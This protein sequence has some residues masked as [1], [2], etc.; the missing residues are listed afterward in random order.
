MAATGSKQLQKKKVAR[1]LGSTEGSRLLISCSG[2]D[3]VPADRQLVADIV[4]KYHQA[5]A[6]CFAA[7]DNDKALRKAHAFLKPLYA[8]RA[9]RSEIQLLEVPPA[10]SG[11][12]TFHAWIGPGI[13]G[14]KLRDFDKSQ[15]TAEG[16]DKWPLGW[17]NE[18]GVVCYER[19]AGRIR[20][21]RPGS[22][23]VPDG[24]F[25]KG[26]VKTKELA[27]AV[28]NPADHYVVIEPGGAMRYMRTSEVARAFMIPVN[29]A[30]T[31]VL[32]GQRLAEKGAKAL[33]AVQAVSCLGRCIHT[34]VARRIVHM[35][36]SRGALPAEPTYG[37]A[38]SGIDTFAAAVE[39]E[40]DGKFE[41]VFASEKER[42][43][44]D[45]LRCAWGRYG[46]TA[47]T[48]FRDACGADA[49]T[50]P[51]VDLW[52]CSPTCESY[53]K[54]N[55]DRQVEVQNLSLGKVW[56]SLQYVVNMRPRVVVMEN[57][58]EVGATGPMS[59][60]ISRL[61]GYAIYGGMLDPRSTAHA[62]IA[63]ER[64][65]WVMLRRD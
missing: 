12:A 32:L 49:T 62:P 9:A 34:G 64:Y 42:R 48:C 7:G 61:E 58:A 56:K 29:S 31:S 13:Q 22:D 37:S 30:L 2:S 53:S 55:H 16:L 1:M 57:V 5:V 47:E 24:E 18:V 50:A 60:L 10:T 28:A 8:R 52:V 46:L 21:E 19:A 33:S 65:F 59:G 25:V 40:F 45:A 38:F 26:L 20:R 17:L 41:Y 39:A 11:P 6:A 43:P 44:R 54:R 27:T 14:E 23:G 36:K 4:T 51:T 63:R 35:L 15:R 3:L